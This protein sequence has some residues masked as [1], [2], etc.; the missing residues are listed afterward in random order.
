[1]W[2]TYDLGSGGD[3][4]GIYAWLDDNKAIE[5][6]NNCAYISDYEYPET[7][8]T[9][10]NFVDFFKKELEKNINFK[11]GNRI[12]IVRKSLDTDKKGKSIG[13]FVIGKRRANT[14]EGFGTKTENTIDE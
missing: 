12:Y 7:I 9:D 3:F 4:Q 6:G 2:L 5:C 13:S 14:W 11:S 10:M 8:T 1:M